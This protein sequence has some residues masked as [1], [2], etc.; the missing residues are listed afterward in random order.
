M[1]VSGKSENIASEE[2][3]NIPER[4]V[5]SDGGISAVHLKGSCVILYESSNCRGNHI[6]MRHGTMS[7]SDLKLVG[8]DNRAKSIGPCGVVRID[9]ETETITQ[10]FG[11]PSLLTILFSLSNG[12]MFIFYLRERNKEKNR[13]RVLNY[14]LPSIRFENNENT[15]SN[16]PYQSIY[17]EEPT[18]NLD[19][20]KRMSLP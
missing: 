16:H 2:C 8:F 12:L 11:I 10:P 1:I 14:P 20:I 17:T 7:H 9:V 19:S 15:T 13:R 4:F 5:G 18:K 6:I 3:E